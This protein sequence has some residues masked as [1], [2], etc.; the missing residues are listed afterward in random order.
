[1][2]VIIQ[3]YHE[4][5]VIPEILRYNELMYPMIMPEESNNILRDLGLLK[6]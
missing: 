4:V 1:M 3:K 6:N 2:H 5:L